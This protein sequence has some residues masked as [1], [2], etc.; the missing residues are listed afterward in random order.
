MNQKM[1]GAEALMRIMVGIISGV[2]LSAWKIVV[3]AITIVHFFVTL[4]TGKRNKDMAEFCEI[5]NTQL[6]CFSRYMTF[7]SNERP[8]P[9]RPLSKNISTFGKGTSK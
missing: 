3:M 8:F 2:I 6:Y 9:F 7:V 4:S 5:W 1:E